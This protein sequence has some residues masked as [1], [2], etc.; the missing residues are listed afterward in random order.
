M[1]EIREMVEGVFRVLENREKLGRKV[2][3]I[4]VEK[5]IPAQNK[6]NFQQSSQSWNKRQ[7]NDR[8]DYNRQPRQSFRAEVPHYELNTSLERIFM[9]NK[10]KNILRPP[11][12]ML[13]LESMRDKSRY[14]AHH[15][16]FGH[17]TNDCRNLYGQVMH[18]IT[19]E[20]L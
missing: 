7:K 2:T 3:A 17:L 5:E 11:A 18:T 20:G 6:R 14:C 13:I 12:K 1:A 16:D 10:D 9:E 8:E 15:E 19:K 4:S